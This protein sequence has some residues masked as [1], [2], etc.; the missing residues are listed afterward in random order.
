MKISGENGTQLDTKTINYADKL[1]DQAPKM[2][3]SMTRN[4]GQ[5]YSVGNYLM[6]GK[7]LGKGHFARVEEATHRIIGK[8]VSRFILLRATTDE[9]RLADECFM[10]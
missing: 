6:N 4:K 3:T 2:K 7:V 1:I 5:V 8:K 10:N 9:T